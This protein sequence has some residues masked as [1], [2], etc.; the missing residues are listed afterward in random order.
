VA[1]R[2][3]RAHPGCNSLRDDYSLRPARTARR[4]AFSVSPRGHS[5]VDVRMNPAGR[6][7]AHGQPLRAPDV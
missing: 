4:P 6:G 1:P 7:R 3:A 2:A 5:I